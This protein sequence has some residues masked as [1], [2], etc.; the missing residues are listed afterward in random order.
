MFNSIFKAIKSAINYVKALIIEPKKV[1]AKIVDV[2][3]KELKPLD[4]KLFRNPKTRPMWVKGL[5]DD[6]IYGRI[7][8]L[9]NLD[10]TIREQ[11]LERG[12]K[13]VIKQSTR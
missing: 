4:F 2:E 10:R 13:H 9:P 7:K 6:Y 8:S 3:L 11:C 1:K 5:F 12:F